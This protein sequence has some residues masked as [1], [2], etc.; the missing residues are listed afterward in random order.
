MLILNILNSSK[1]IVGR[2][3]KKPPLKRNVKGSVGEWLC[4]RR[5][6]RVTKIK[7]TLDEMPFLY[8]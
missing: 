7:R 2:H 3:A 8:N 5:I 1:Y 6:R 4:A